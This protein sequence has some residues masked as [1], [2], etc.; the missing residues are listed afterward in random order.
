M[1]EH[2]LR[3]VGSIAAR[4][5][6]RTDLTFDDLTQEGIIGLMKAAFKFDAS[7][8]YKFSTYATPWIE[9]SIRRALSEQGLIIRL[10][11]YKYEEVCRL[12]AVITRLAPTGEARPPIEQIAQEMDLPVEKVLELFSITNQPD[13]LDEIINHHRNSEH[14]KYFFE[15]DRNTP[16]PDKLAEQSALREEIDAAL[17]ILTAREERI[18]RLRYGLDDGC[19]R[20]LVE[21]GDIF[22]LSRERIRQIEADAFA[23]LRRSEEVHKLREFI[24]GG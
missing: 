19:A 2:N 12:A 22:G 15:P 18:L 24:D 8:G 10:P 23:K 5:V 14:D 16:Q 20:T 21:I 6:R 7:L 4:F 17:S 11:V 13:S 3:L 9:Q 1:T